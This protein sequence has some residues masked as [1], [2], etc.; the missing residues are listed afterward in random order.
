MPFKPGQSGNPSGTKTMR[1]WTAALQRALLQYKDKKLK[2][3]PGEAL[4]YIADDVV[5]KAIEGSPRRAR[6]SST[7][8]RA[9]RCRRSQGPAAR[10]CS[11]RSPGDR[12]APQG[13]EE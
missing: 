7:G 8:S 13:L 1:P 9:S 10:T 4:R 6:R 12:E 3:K 11:R 2:I 5:Q